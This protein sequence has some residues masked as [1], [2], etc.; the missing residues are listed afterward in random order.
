MKAFKTFE[1]NGTK[2]EYFILD[3]KKALAFGWKF[4]I[5]V[6]HTNAQNSLVIRNRYYSNTELGVMEGVNYWSKY[7]R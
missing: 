3:N 6:R 2:R 7:T 4:S 5:E 1:I